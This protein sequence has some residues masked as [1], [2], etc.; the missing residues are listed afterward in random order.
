MI[1]LREASAEDCD[2]LYEWANDPKV[3]ENSFHTEQIS[4]KEHVSWFARMMEADEVRQFI[5]MDQD[6]PVGQIRIRLQGEEAEIGYSVPA[7]HR[8]KGYGRKLLELLFQK[9][10]TDFSQVHFL[11]AKVKAGNY[12]SK[13]LFESEG[14]VME[15]LCY[16]KQIS[17]GGGYRIGDFRPAAAPEHCLNGKA[18]A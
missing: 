14:Y 15:H 16:Q 4:Y 1:F 11:A 3:R 6:Q 17:S 5:L 2:L 13:K 10:Q 18:V 12:A 9:V 7:S 8:G